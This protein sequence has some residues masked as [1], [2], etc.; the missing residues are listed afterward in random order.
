ME[1]IDIKELVNVLFKKLYVIIIVTVIGAIAGFLYSKFMIKPMY[2][3]TTSFVLS[4]A[5][6]IQDNI[7]VGA[8]T[9]NDITLNQ[10]LVSTYSE[11]VKSKAIAKKVIN[12]LN[13]NM[14]EEE[15]MSN[16]T[17]NAKDDTELILISV[18]NENPRLSA[19]IANSLV[20]VFKDKITEV[21]KIENLTVIDI[22][23]PSLYPYNIGT[24]KNTCLFG[25]IGMI[26]SCGIIF[27]IF[28]FDNTVKKQE[29]V[30]ALLG[31]P[32]IASITKYNE[33]LEA[34]NIYGN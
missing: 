19:D 33:E 29:D 8:I 25:I 26:L 1:E 9:Q 16:I 32:V 27:L 3:S 22:A 18:S 4:K 28:Y 15:F 14:T 12:N 5:N 11:I 24:L 2:K 13:L 7:Q 23:E 6:D 34:E 10:K 20:E 17:V 31:I 30:E 21:Y